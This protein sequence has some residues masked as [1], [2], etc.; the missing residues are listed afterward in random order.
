MRWKCKITANLIQNVALGK[1]QKQLF[2][3]IGIQFRSNAAN[4]TIENGRENYYFHVVIKLS[5][6]FP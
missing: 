6:G 2:I 1:K 4:K 3:Y 5:F